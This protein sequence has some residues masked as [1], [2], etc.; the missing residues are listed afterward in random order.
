MAKAS[1][2]ERA[3]AA[4]TDIVRRL[5][6]AGHVAYFAGGCVRDELLGLR[7]TD[8]DVA[9][10][11]T[12]DRVASLFDRTHLVGLAFGVVLVNL[13]GCQIEVATFRADG[14][15][16][17]SRHPDSVEFSDAKSD[18]ARRDFTINAL[19]LDPLATPGEAPGPSGESQPALFPGQHAAPRMAGAPIVVRGWV[20]DE[21]GGVDDLRAGRIRAVGDPSHRLAEDHL[22]ALRAVRFA[23][24]LGFEIDSATAR[25]IREHAMELR[26]ISRER[27]GEEVRRMMDLPTRALAATLLQELGL[28]APVLDDSSQAI[29][30]PTLAGLTFASDEQMQTGHPPAATDQLASENSRVPPQVLLLLRPRIRYGTSLAAW[31]MDRLQARAQLGAMLPWQ[32]GKPAAKARAALVIRLRQALCL[33]NDERDDLGEVME[34][35][36]VLIEAWRGLSVA[37]QKRVVA[38]RWFREALRLVLVRDGVLGLEIAHRTIELHATPTGIA[39]EPFVTGDDLIAIGMRPSPQFR[40]VLDRVF[41]AQLEGRVS[42]K[43]EALELAVELRV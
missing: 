22:R 11:A 20:L 9:T 2:P 17:D 40:S 31:L 24:R 19:F 25:A 32:L 30:L 16:S 14:P 43:S 36:A 42:S 7:P 39:P 18:A 28:D 34:G 37:G 26:G 13:D 21:V 10:D 38:R 29:P 6:Q 4:A 1:D 5:R 33:S 27:I 15:Y 12:P 35:A 3:R 23:A 41:D 8:Y